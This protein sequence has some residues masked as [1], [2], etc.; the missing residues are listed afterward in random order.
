M[1]VT[2]AEILRNL[3]SERNL[4]QLQLASKLF[5]SRA[6]IASWENGRRVPNPLLI[7]RLAEVL[8][9]NIAALMYAAAVDSEP[10]NVIMVDDEE[11]I[12]AGAMQTLYEVMPEA[13]ITGFS[14]VSEAI[15][16]ARGVCKVFCV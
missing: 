6:C 14:K 3:R 4:S 16:F 1:K 13:E 5:V 2:F 11:V 12:L 8:N 9:V 15:T 7:T 10:L